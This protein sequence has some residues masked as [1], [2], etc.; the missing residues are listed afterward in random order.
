MR[1]LTFSLCG[2]MGLACTYRTDLA[3]GQGGMGGSTLT[4]AA[5]TGGTTSTGGSGAT[6]ND[7]ACTAD[8]DCTQ[9]VYATTPGNPQECEGALGC[10]G[11]PVMN[12]T[13]CATNE[14]AWQAHCSNRGYEVPMC[15][16]IVPCGGESGPSCRNGMCGYWCN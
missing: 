14:A 10:C 6:S 9:C 11:G 7:H 2:L 5:T 16:C 8:G 4:A 15:P 3:D 13:A 1:L 12:K